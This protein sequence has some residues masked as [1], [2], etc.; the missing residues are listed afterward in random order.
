[1]KIEIENLGAIKHAEINLNKKLTVFCGPN[2]SG[3]TYA[4]FIIYALTK[5]GLK[6]FRSKG[7]SN[8]I[9][10]LIKNQS[11]TFEIKVDDIWNY[12]NEELDSIKESLDSIYG[13]SEEISNNLFKDFSIKILENKN[14]FSD[15]ILKMNFENELKLNNITIKIK[16]E[17]NTKSIKLS[18]KNKT[19]SK[20]NIEMLNLFLNAKL[21][22]LIGFYPFTSSHI[23]PVERNSIYTFSKELSIQK[24]E[25]FERAQELG[26]KSNNRDPFH[27]LLKSS[28]RYPM[29][30]RDGLEIAEDLF[31]YSK[32]R[33][34]FYEFAEEIES[35]LLQGK[36][37]INK[38]G[39]VQFAS[40]KAK[41]KKI[42]IH[43]SASIVKTLSSL[44]FYLKHIATKNEMIIIDEPELNLHP[45][46]QV[47]LTRVFAK[48]INKGF[49]ILISTHS[50][51]IIREINNLIMAS[52]ENTGTK[53][54]AAKLGYS[55]DEKL[56]ND[57]VSAYLFNYKNK[58]S[59]NVTIS[60]IE[61]TETGFDVL[62]IDQTV[63]ELND[64]SEELFYSIKY[65][66]RK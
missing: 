16:K 51:Y 13:I 32:T 36:V 5:S 56:K 48:L 40:N 28:K 50:D 6:Y 66:H 2:N 65:D 64:V 60:P 57:T 39:D 1:M 52:S 27:W 26:T 55:E 9:T 25:F 17:N 44:I 3:K 54:I 62:T 61:V 38:D 22:S 35:E 24:Q 4:A 7:R 11:A 59:R 33:T 43:L 21:Y 47:Y 30:I 34:E 45:N 41:S 23:L 37:T 19:V 10:E 15:S 8:L 18:L 58:T 42:P 63:E 46:N 53:K 20:D 31:N 14:E 12:R 29:P 49:R